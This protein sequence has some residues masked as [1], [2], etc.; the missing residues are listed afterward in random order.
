MRQENLFM[1]EKIQIE[2]T[3]KINADYKIHNRA[4]MKY[5]LRNRNQKE[6]NH[7]RIQDSKKLGSITY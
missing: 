1:N 3:K 5:A 7:N 4:N 6:R 2:Q